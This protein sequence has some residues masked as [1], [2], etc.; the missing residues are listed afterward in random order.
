MRKPTIRISAAKMGI[1]ATPARNVVDMHA[2]IDGS[3][4]VIEVEAI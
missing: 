4:G 2:L 1:E 3:S